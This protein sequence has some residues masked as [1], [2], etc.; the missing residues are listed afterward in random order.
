MSCPL[1]PQRS[2][3]C[4]TTQTQPEDP[5]LHQ[6][7]SG[8]P[9]EQAVMVCPLLWHQRAAAT[10]RRRAAPLEA[11]QRS[12]IRAAEGVFR[13]SVVSET[14]HVRWVGPS[15]KWRPSYTDARPHPLK[16][17]PKPPLLSVTPFRCQAYV[18]ADPSQQ[19]GMGSARGIQRKW[20]T[21]QETL[22][23]LLSNP[24]APCP[25]NPS[26]AGILTL[27]LKPL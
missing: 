21:L 20:E 1:M 11:G 27:T 7:R 6:K 13:A 18:N 19:E 5:R 8:W 16:P 10:F 23:E 4:L 2:G 26:L 24:E 12:H 22:S 14:T 17:N 3:R 25:V 15:T 9:D